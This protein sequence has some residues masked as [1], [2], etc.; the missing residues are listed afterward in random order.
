MMKSI[1][2]MAAALLIVNAS[3][4]AAQQHQHG[5]DTAQARAGH[6]GQMGHMGGMGQ[7]GEMGQMG[8]AGHGM[9]LHAFHPARLIEQRADLALTD[10]QMTRLEAIR[11]E[12]TTAHDQARTTHDQHRDQMTEALKG[13]RPDPEAVQTHFMAAHAAMG[14]AHWAEM[15]AGL[16]AMA[17]LTDEQ[18]AKVKAAMTGGGMQ[19]RHGQGGQEMR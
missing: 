19:H 4:M 7:M 14:L 2:G 8:M 1:T 3:G 17:V 15:Q 11:A 6:M 5:Q 16:Q 9:A 10:D 18:R 13:E 12:A